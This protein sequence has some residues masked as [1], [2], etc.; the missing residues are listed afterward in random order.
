MKKMNSARLTI[1]LLLAVSMLVQGVVAQRA[2]RKD[3][4]IALDILNT[5][6]DYDDYGIFD[7]VTVQVKSGAVTLTGKV[8]MPHK[9][10]EIEK[11]VKRVR[12]IEGVLNQIEVLP[13]SQFDDDLR[14]R[15]ANTIYNNA[16]FWQYSTRKK[17]PI[18][19]I[20]RG[21]RVTLTGIVNNDLDRKLAA[22]LARQG[23]AGYVTNELK[24]EEEARQEFEK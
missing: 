24:T 14:V 16:N 8:T 18:H 22:S 3:F 21:N 5:V 1:G 6:N 19:I 12:G 13:A 23:G 4:Q 9:R 20:V 15:I 2:P 10:N 17:P 11:R 7:D